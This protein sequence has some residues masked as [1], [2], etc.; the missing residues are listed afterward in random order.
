[1][2]DQQQRRDSWSRYWA[3]GALHSCATSFDGNYD[4]AIGEFSWRA[5]CATLRGGGARARRRHGQ[6]RTA[7][8]AVD[9]LG[10]DGRLPGVD[11][12]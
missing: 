9:P 5:V 6:R 8:H 12:V 1:M 4:D 11:V 10:A 7:A 2:S 3:G